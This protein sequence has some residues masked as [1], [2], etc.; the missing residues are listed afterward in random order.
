MKPTP[1]CRLFFG[2]LWLFT[3]LPTIWAYQEARVAPKTAPP[4]SPAER[5]AM[6]NVKTKTIREVTAALAAPAMEGRGTAQPGGARAA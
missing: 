5:K 3:S 6:A 2:A 4:L 1:L